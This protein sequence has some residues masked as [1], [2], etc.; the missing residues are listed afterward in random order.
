MTFIERY[1]KIQ[2]HL[3]LSC[4]VWG[5]VRVSDGHYES[6][7]TISLSH[8]KCAEHL[9]GPCN[10]SG[11]II[12][13]GADITL[14]SIRSTQLHTRFNWLKHILSKQKVPI[15]NTTKK[16]QSFWIPLLLCPVTLFITVNRAAF[17]TLS[18]Y[19]KLQNAPWSDEY[20]VHKI[21][22]DVHLMCQLHVTVELYRVSC[23]LSYAVSHFILN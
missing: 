16:I 15:S 1:P 10:N 23:V 13:S 14:L 12:D 18:I 2:K 19:Y 6:N 20:S 4:L 22:L 3:S 8:Y 9:Q 7:F 17:L 21:N 11:F 5:T